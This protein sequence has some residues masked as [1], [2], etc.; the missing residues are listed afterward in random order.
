MN[1]PV[2]SYHSYLSGTITTNDDYNVTQS[3]SIIPFSGPTDDSEYR[4]ICVN[5]NTFIDSNNNSTSY[6]VNYN[7]TAKNTEKNLIVQ[8]T[9]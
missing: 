7:I 3:L 4:S 6:F 8:L 1:A 9:K 5:M 2:K